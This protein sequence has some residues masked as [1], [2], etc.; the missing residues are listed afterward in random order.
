MVVPSETLVNFEVSVYVKGFLL[1]F[2][3]SRGVEDPNF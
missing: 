3:Q 2:P 1:F